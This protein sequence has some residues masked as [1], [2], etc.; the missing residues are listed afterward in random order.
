[1]QKGN[2]GPLTQILPIILRWWQWR[3]KASVGASESAH[4]ACPWSQPVPSCQS[5]VITVSAEESCLIQSCVPSQGGQNSIIRITQGAKSW[6]PPSQLGA[7]L[8]GYLS[9]KTASSVSWAFHWDQ[10]TPEVLPVPG[11]ASSLPL[12]FP[13]Y[14]R[15]WSEEQSLIKLSHAKIP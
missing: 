9:F 8:Q 5:T 11:L 2:V 10:L 1:M 14:Q 4:I 3:V 15:C 13:S 7:N 12:P 6:P